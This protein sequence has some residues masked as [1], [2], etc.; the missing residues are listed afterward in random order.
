MAVLESLDAAH[1][2]EV[3][4]G[5]RDA[6]RVH[7]EKLNRLNVYPVPDGD[8]G[9]NLAFTLGSVLAGALSRRTASAGELLRKVDVRKVIL[10]H[11]QTTARF[12]I[13]S[14]NDARPR[15]AATTAQRVEMVGQRAG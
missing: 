6:L 10:R 8:T 9:S 13:Q 2:R 5:Y 12:F 11:D 4:V 3:V 15:W 7:Q 14:M 1:L